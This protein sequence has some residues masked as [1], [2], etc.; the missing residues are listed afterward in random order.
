ML[1]LIEIIEWLKIS[2]ADVKHSFEK[3]A[4]V[5]NEKFNS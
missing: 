2:A 3:N 5:D 4:V 1:A